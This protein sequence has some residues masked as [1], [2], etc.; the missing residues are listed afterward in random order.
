MSLQQIDFGGVLRWVQLPDD[1]GMAGRFGL[2][3]VA[4]FVDET[5][6]RA[7]GAPVTL[8]VDRSELQAVAGRD[9]FAGLVA[10][11]GAVYPDLAAM[12]VPI[13]IRAEVRGYLP[14]VLNDMIVAAPDHP[15]GFEPAGPVLPVPMQPLPVAL[16][17]RVTREAADLPV[18][19]AGADVVL[20]GHWPHEPPLGATQPIITAELVEVRPALA[21]DEAAGAAVRRINVTPALPATRLG[22]SA[23]AGATRIVLEDRGGL[24]PGRWLELSPGDAARA[25]IVRIAAVAALP[26]SPFAGEVTLVHPLGFAH[27]AGSAA[28][29][30]TITAVGPSRALTRA[31]A[32]G[33][34]TLFVDLASGLFASG[35]LRIGT[36][37]TAQVR[38]VRAYATQTDAEGFFRLP[39]VHRIAQAFLDISDGL[40]ALTDHPWRPANDGPLD[41]V[42]L[43]LPP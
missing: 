22:S 6:G 12:P 5:S 16:A 9:G 40:T 37:N 10:V 38:R 26:P 3:W 36:G 15:Q 13:E 4:R 14:V 7:V 35:W 19:V 18:P 28:E 25:E 42:D 39:P 1:P 20:S 23:P 11:P 31:A 8:R 41:R 43:T 29:R 21:A 27:V 24:L 30:R 32:L 17:G 34:R 33:G 2:V